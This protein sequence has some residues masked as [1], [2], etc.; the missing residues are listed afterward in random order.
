[1]AHSLKIAGAFAI[2]V[3]LSGCSMVPHTNTSAQKLNHVL[4][5]QQQAS[6]A[7][8]ADDMEHASALY[9]KLTRLIPQEADY[10]YM[11]GNTYVRLQQPDQAVQAYQ[12]AIARNPNHSRAWHNL[13]IVR[14]R[15][16]MAAFVSSAGT[17]K[18]GDPMNEVSTQLADQLARISSGGGKPADQA[19]PLPFTAAER[20][21]PLTRM[22]H[23]RGSKPAGAGQQ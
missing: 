9:L 4:T 10:W 1:M 13:G 12:Q 16:A 6:E 17:A 21:D 11:L 15:Q 23:V 3:L 2:A 22:Q 7:Y 19:A 5:T 18:A 14:M 20:L 8:Q